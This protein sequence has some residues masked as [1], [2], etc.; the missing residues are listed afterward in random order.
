MQFQRIFICYFSCVSECDL[1]LHTRRTSCINHGY[2]VEKFV[3]AFFVA[4]FHETNSYS[5]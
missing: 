2:C 1:V 5:E 4:F 3:V